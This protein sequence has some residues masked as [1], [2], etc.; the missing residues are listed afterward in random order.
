MQ[1]AAFIVWW[2][3]TVCSFSLLSESALLS[4]QYRDNGWEHR[5]LKETRVSQK[6]SL[7]WSSHNS[8]L[9]LIRLYVKLLLIGQENQS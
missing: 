3:V 5:V 8:P 7:I 2:W 6:Y 1:S 4:C 9:V